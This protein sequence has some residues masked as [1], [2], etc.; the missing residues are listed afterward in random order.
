MAE[1]KAAEAMET[2]KYRI[3]L[4][5]VKRF[6]LK[7]RAKRAPRFIRLFVRKHLRIPL[8][9][10]AI[11][12]EVNEAIWARSIS[13]IPNKLDIEVLIEGKAARVFLK[14]GKQL[15]EF[16]DTKK[17][18]EKK[19]KEEAEK[20]EKE[21]KEEKKEAADAK[22]EQEKKLEEKKLKEKN[23]QALEMARK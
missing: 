8:E 6:P 3:N 2:K 16:L 10:T 1:K 7:M 11:S 9:N 22:T 19:K 13:N 15:K 14:D 21:S 20:K 18:S 4:N 17:A 5:P 23:S 12:G